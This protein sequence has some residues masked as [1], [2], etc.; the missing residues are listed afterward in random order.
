MTR[1]TLSPLHQFHAILGSSL[2]Y[3]SIAK[4]FDRLLNAPKIDDKYPPHNIIKL[5]E[6][7]YVVELAT[8]G[9]TKEE[10]DITVNDGTLTIKGS[11]TPDEEAVQYLHKGISSRSFTKSISIVDTVEVRDAKYEDGILYI[12]LENVI[13]ESK[14]PRTIEIRSALKVR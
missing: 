13:P 12:F 10:I 11:K 6:Y 9:F 4:E 2:G 3:D 8:A 14:K 1:I 5:S 7:S